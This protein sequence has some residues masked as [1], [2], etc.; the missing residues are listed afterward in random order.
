[1]IHE[2]RQNFAKYFSENKSFSPKHG[3]KHE[4]TNKD[5]NKKIILMKI[6]Q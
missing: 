4:P 5:I 3:G 1:M 6:L 2:I